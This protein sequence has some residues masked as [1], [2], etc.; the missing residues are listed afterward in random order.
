M[1]VGA[2]DYTAQVIVG[3]QS[4]EKLL[5]Y[6]IIKLQ[7][8]TIRASIKKTDTPK[9]AIAQTDLAGEGGASVTDNTI[10][11]SDTSVNSNYMQESTNDTIKFQMANNVGDGADAID[12]I[13]ENKELKQQ[14]E[15][16]R[17]ELQLS[18][19]AVADMKSARAFVRRLESLYGINYD[20]AAF[21][22]L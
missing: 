2:N 12:L 8:T 10:S 4:D 18:K 11:Q 15:R 9:P 22:R 14:N 21:T 5:L 7:P 20:T 16:L 6:D 19:S 1:R 3:K 13:K 17:G